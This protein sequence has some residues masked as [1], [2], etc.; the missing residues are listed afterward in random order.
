MR[1]EPQILVVDEARPRDVMTIEELV[2]AET[3]E[4]AGAGDSEDLAVEARL[5][6]DLIGACYGWTWGGTCE[7]D[8][9]WVAP[10]S[11][12]NGL[13]SQLLRTAELVAAERGCFQVVLLTYDLQ[14][15]GYYE[16]R[17][18]KMVGRVDDYPLGS[19]ALWFRRPLGPAADNDRRKG[20]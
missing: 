10:S 9:L 3:I 4:R 20:S 7:L 6:G 13:G 18:Y 15:P 12:N 16:R 17:G 14:A 1:S 8:T 19:A 5:D 11:R 2:R